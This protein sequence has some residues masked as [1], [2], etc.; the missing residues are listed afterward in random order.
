VVNDKKEID[1]FLKIQIVFSHCSKW[2]VDLVHIYL[3]YC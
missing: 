2:S 3:L 1:V